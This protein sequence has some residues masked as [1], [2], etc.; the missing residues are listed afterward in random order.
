MTSMRLY[1]E[2]ALVTVGLAANLRNLSD[3]ENIECSRSS[4]SISLATNQ[5]AR[6]R[7]NARNR[8]NSCIDVY[9]PFL[10]PFDSQ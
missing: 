7:L 3:I 10:T 6:P 8:F 1:Y 4:E 9:D 5:S 2:D